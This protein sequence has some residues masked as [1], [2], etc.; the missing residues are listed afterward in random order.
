MRVWIHFAGSEKISPVSQQSLS[1]RGVRYVYGAVRVIVEE[2]RGDDV[3][4]GNDLEKRF[5]SELDQAVAK[6]D[7]LRDQIQKARVR[8]FL[9]DN[10]VNK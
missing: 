4:G 1:E 3:G 2:E 6:Y 9:S 8:V 7:D 10:R 5:R